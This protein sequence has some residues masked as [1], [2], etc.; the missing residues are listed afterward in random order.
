[1]PFSRYLRTFT[2]EDRSIV[3]AVKLNE[4]ERCASCGLTQAE[5]DEDPTAYEAAQVACPWCAMKDRAREADDTDVSAPGASIRLLPR[6]A[7]ERL[8]SIRPKRP[9]SPRERARQ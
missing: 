9:L 1:M 6:K 3:V 8:R 5:F 7:A 4:A 2:N